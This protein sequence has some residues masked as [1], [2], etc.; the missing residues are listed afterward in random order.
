MGWVRAEGTTLRG[1]RS[2]GLFVG[3]ALGLLP[4]VTSSLEFRTGHHLGSNG[5]G[6]AGRGGQGL[7]KD[8]CK[9]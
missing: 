2:F 7:P 5:P 8:P 3:W 1:F 4:G 6:E 9:A